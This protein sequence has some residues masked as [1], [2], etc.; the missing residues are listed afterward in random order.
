ME[1]REPLGRVYRPRLI[2]AQVEDGLETA[3]AVLIEGIRSCGKTMTALNAAHSYAFLDS[4]DSR[5]L[6]EVAPEALLVGETP[7]LLD[8]WQLAPDLWNPVRRAV[9]AA[10][11][12]GRFI[13][14][15]SAVP[16]D[17]ITR[18]TGAGRFLRLREHT[19]AWAERPLAEVFAPVSLSRLFA[20][21]V[22]A[23][24]LGATMDYAQVIEELARPGF[25]GMY[26]LSSSRGL[27]MLRA[28]I[29]D[30]SRLD[31][32][33][34][35]DMRHDPI[36]IQ[37][38]MA[39]LARST[40]SDVTFTTL[41][42]DVR[43]VAPGIKPETVASYVNVLERVFAVDRQKAWTPSLTSRAR[44]R[45][46]PKLHLADP[47][48]AVA[49]MGVTARAL[50][51]DVLVAGL[52]FESAVIHDLRVHTQ[53]L[54]GQIR[55]YRDSNGHEMDAV[56][57]LPDGTWGAVEVKLGG[58][59]AG[60]GAK[61]LNAAVGQLDYGSS[62]RPSFRLIVTGTGGTYVMTDG[63][64]TCPLAALRP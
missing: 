3:G 30:V 14:T 43:A 47:S 32:P 58:G 11:Q 27:A 7:R 1:T 57:L 9:D 23:P 13:L 19:L 34:L 42:A 5:R 39:S 45:T 20:G 50:S 40:A 22:P 46:S 56:V 55:H 35:V 44:L 29:D 52:V 36:V 28:Y 63:T 38:L 51:G 54:G 48:L 2:D 18:H 21:E 12:P 17:D 25:P 31:V 4:P 37:Q 26:S 15:G 53:A 33:S 64:I 6:A 10:D 24:D 41:A 49:A 8:E 61:S 62:P 60:A 59:Q 16:A